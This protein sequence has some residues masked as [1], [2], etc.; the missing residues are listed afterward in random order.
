MQQCIYISH[1]LLFP[2]YLI[3]TNSWQCLWKHS[4]V[5]GLYENGVPTVRN[6]MSLLSVCGMTVWEHANLKSPAKESDR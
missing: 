2:I 4:Q 3:L 6:H 1:F 5:K